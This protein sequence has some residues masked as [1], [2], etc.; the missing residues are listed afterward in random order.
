MATIEIEKWQKILHFFETKF[1]E[2]ETPDMD[3]IL[4]LIGVQELGKINKK[5]K[6]DD[7]LNLMHIAVC[8]L[9]EPYGFYLY[10][11]IDKEGW[12]HYTLNEQL[13]QLKAN[14]QQL[15]MKKAVILYFEDLDLI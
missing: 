4:F 6:K 9:L 13:P 3:A 10:E 5:F 2:G 12:P 11:G 15:L 1:T 14:E 7:K 8:R